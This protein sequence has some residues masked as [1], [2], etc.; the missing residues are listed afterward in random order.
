MRHRC[1][2]VCACPC[3][4]HSTW[5]G[6][7]KLCILFQVSESHFSVECKKKC[8]SFAGNRRSTFG[9]GWEWC[10]SRGT[11]T[12][13]WPDQASGRRTGSGH[14]IWRVWGPCKAM[15]GQSKGGSHEFSVGVWEL[16]K[17]I[18]LQIFR[19]TH[20]QK[21]GCCSHIHT[22]GTCMDVFESIFESIWN[23]VTQRRSLFGFFQ[24]HSKARGWFVLVHGCRGL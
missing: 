17:V 8:R 22:V 7:Q 11:W 16:R 12:W 19:N 2:H 6:R 9:S 24:C 10:R 13:K 15:Q 1:V 23:Y 5:N 3:M 21:D 20:L 18:C 4:K 14:W